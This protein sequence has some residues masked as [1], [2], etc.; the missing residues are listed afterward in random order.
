[1]LI[2]AEIQK[3]PNL[4]ADNRKLSG[5]YTTEKTPNFASEHMFVCHVVRVLAGNI[6]LIY[7]PENIHPA[8]KIIRLRIN[9]IDTTD[10]T[11]QATAFLKN[12]IVRSKSILYLNPRWETGKGQ[13]VADVFIDGVSI[14]NTMIDNNLAQLI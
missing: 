5:F 6:I 7:L 2:C 3:T 11:R 1:M 4:S 14:A 9:G 10:T 8:V 13:M 12:A